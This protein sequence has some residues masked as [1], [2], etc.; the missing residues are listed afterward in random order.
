M[1]NKDIPEFLR[2]RPRFV[3]AHVLKRWED[4]WHTSKAVKKTEDEKYLVQSTTSSNKWYTVNF[5]DESSHPS[6][7]CADW[8]K[9]KLPCKHFCAVF[10]NT[11]R[12]WNDLSPLYK[13]LSILNLD[14]IC[15]NQTPA[16][17]QDNRQ[18][19]EKVSWAC[20]K[21][22]IDTDDSRLVVVRV[23]K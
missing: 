5:G 1:Y 21:Q 12:K 13:S 15:L 17:S 18:E 9:T 16:V 7:Q 2:N 14:E 3:V 19:Q 11:E 23:R 8:N 4:C 6:C 20:T 22:S 10:K